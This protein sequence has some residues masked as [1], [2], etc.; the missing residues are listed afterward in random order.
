MT[1]GNVYVASVAMGA[2]DE[3]TLKA[4]IEAEAYEGPSLIIAYSHCIA[5]GIAD[6][7]IAMQHQKAL[8]DS[9]QWLLYRYSPDR[10][11]AGEAALKLDSR[12]IKIPVEQFLK[13]ENR[14]NMVLKTNPEQAKALF[15]EAQSD[16][17]TRWK[18]YQYLSSQPGSGAAPAK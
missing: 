2:R 13:M 16:V 17:D 7:S 4:F 8:V 14:F 6:M 10:A 15:A 1:Y 11:K 18:F 5:H 9:G 3:H 12:G